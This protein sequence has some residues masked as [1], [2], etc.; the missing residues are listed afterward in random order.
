MKRPS[1]QFY[2][3]D[4]TG[5]I[6]LRR[7][8]EAARSGWMDILCALH[9]SDDYGYVRWPLV[10]LAQ[11]AGV[12][13]KLAKELSAK[14]VLKGADRGRVVYI[15]TPRHAGKDGEPVTLIDVEGPC[16]YSSKMVRDEWLRSRRG[17]STRF[18][19]DNQPDGVVDGKATP[20]Q[21][22][23]RRV[24]EEPN[25]GTGYGPSS[26]S[27]SS[28]S[29]LRSD[30]G[31]E[32][33]A[34]HSKPTKKR[35]EAENIEFP[36]WWPQQ[37]WAAFAEMRRSKRATLTVDA[38]KLAIRTL[39]ELRD[40]GQNP[41]AVLEQ[42]ILNSYKG[43]FPVKQSNGGRNGGSI[44]NQSFGS[45]L[46]RRVDARSSGG[47]LGERGAEIVVPAGAARAAGDR[48]D[49]ERPGCA[50]DAA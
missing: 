40:E 19:T 26:L 31:P 29:S 39:T 34:A 6:K 4:W 7:C 24:G 50:A 22:P 38:I 27:S 13:I 49:D 47:L 2:P 1:F 11:V 35:K 21:Q 10:E 3:S 25:G 45:S 18:T 5:N 12:P 42:S 28:E 30:I 46:A 16:W 43:L 33:T 8:S 37:E 32:D 44:T 20:G 9:D 23:T 17:A 36:D 41:V 14:D 48:D 15:H